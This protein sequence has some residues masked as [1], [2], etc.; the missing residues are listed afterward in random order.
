MEF[1]YQEMEHDSCYFKHGAKKEVRGN[2]STNM[3]QI[4]LPNTLAINR[5]TSH[6]TNK[7]QLKQPSV[8]PNLLV[9]Q[10]PQPSL[11][12][13][14]YVILVKFDV[15]SNLVISCNWRDLSSMEEEATPDF[16][17]KF[18]PLNL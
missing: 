9:P 17:T 8:Y 13:N 18:Y 2:S 4:Q 10:F 5:G 15:C 3:D 14:Q 12:Q 16:V 6:S 11:A 7:N 1:I